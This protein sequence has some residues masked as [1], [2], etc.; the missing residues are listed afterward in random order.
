MLLIC[1]SLSSCSDAE[2]DW[3]AT[4]VETWFNVNGIA[5]EEGLDVDL[6]EVAG[7]LIDQAVDEYTNSEQANALDFARENI[8]EMELADQHLENALDSNNPNEIAKAKELR[9]DDVTYVEAEVAIWMTSGNNAAVRTAI[10]ESDLITANF[11]SQGGNCRSA[12]LNQLRTRQEMLVRQLDDPVVEKDL[13]VQDNIYHML[14]EVDTEIQ[15]ILGE[16]EN[17]FCARLGADVIDP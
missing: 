5:V 13:V 11:V 12:R 14:G 17:L 4:A 6:G 9:P 1:I 8:E 2:L 10:N 3:F 15:S 16:S 7:L